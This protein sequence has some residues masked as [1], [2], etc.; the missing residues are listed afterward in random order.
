M[1]GS[2]PAQPIQPEPD[3]IPRDSVT[4]YERPAIATGAGAPY[5]GL[6]AEAFQDTLLQLEPQIA[7]LLLHLIY[8]IF[9][10]ILEFNHR[11][12]LNTNPFLCL[13]DSLMADRN[14]RNLLFVSLNTFDTQARVSY[15]Y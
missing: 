1:S 6:R 13:D 5:G 12:D 15:G 7:R 9:P 10:C 14:N 4:E 3:P 2:V 8:C 11:A